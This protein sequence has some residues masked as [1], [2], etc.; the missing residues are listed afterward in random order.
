M[1]VAP[2]P[3]LLR[4]RPQLA[5]TSTSCR[6][7][8]GIKKCL[9]DAAHTTWSFSS[10]PISCTY[11]FAKRAFKTFYS[12][13]RLG[14]TKLCTLPSSLYW[15]TPNTTHKIYSSHLNVASCTTRILWF[16]FT[17]QHLR[18]RPPAWRYSELVSSSPSECCYCPATA[19]DSLPRHTAPSQCSHRSGRPVPASADWRRK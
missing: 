17:A 6:P 8:L 2:G 11:A 14:D 18:E 10:S 3:Y 13:W 7:S 4:A 5:F 16:I 12:N 9:D 1:S 15:T 19:L